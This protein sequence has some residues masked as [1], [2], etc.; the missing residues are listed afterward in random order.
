MK[1]V[2]RSRRPCGQ[3]F[4]SAFPRTP[5]GQMNEWPRPHRSLLAPDALL[6]GAMA[7]ARTKP[8]DRVAGDARMGACTHFAQGWDYQKLMPLI[9]KSG[10]GWIRDDLGWESVEREK[11][12]YQIPAKTLAWVRAAHAHRLRLLVILNG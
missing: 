9:A 7:H 12:V 8:A 11:G 4:S 1:C 10:L 3:R 6:L 5:E 2:L